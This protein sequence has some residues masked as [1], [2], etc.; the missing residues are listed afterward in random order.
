MPRCRV[1]DAPGR[2][3]RPA[4]GTADD[5]SADEHGDLARARRGRPPH[6]APGPDAADDSTRVFKG[7]GVVV[8]GQIP[9]GGLPPAA[10]VQPAEATSS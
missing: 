4:R 5:S 7:T 2:S 10:P 8:K 6:A 1:R 3:G 9:G